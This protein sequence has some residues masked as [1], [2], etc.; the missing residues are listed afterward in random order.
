MLLRLYLR[1]GYRKKDLGR[2]A[3]SNAKDAD[4]IV[5]L[6][7]PI[8]PGFQVLNQLRYAGLLRSHGP[9]FAENEPPSFLR[10]FDHSV[11]IKS[12]DAP[13]QDGLDE[14]NRVAVNETRV[15]RPVFSAIPTR[16]EFN[17]MRAFERGTV[18]MQV[19][20]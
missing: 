20:L 5:P 1:I 3:R 2:G 10:D 7:R 9:K 16:H 14:T 17:V 19:R 11:A 8:D 6:Q 15:R 18:E 12:M 13:F 4:D